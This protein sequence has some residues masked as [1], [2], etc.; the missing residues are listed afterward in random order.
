MLRAWATIMALRLVGDGVSLRSPVRK[1]CFTFRSATGGR[2]SGETESVSARFRVVG[3]DEV[4]D[5]EREG[6]LWCSEGEV[7][8]VESEE[9]EATTD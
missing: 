7:R 6:T 9:E 4:E 3:S 2:F 1:P 5:E 8:E